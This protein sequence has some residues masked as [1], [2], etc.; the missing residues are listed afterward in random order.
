MRKKT[1]CQRFG[2]FCIASFLACMAF[3]CLAIVPYM[4]HAFRPFVAV[5]MAF[6]RMFAACLLWSFCGLFAVPGFLYSGRNF[7]ARYV[8]KIAVYGLLWPCTCIYTFIGVLHFLWLFCGRMACDRI[9]H[10]IGIWRGSPASRIAAGA[11]AGNN[12]ATRARKE[13]CK[14]TISNLHYVYLWFFWVIFRS[15]TWNFPKN[16]PGSVLD[17]AREMPPEEAGKGRLSESHIY[18]RVWK[19]F[20]QSDIAYNAYVISHRAD[21]SA[22]DPAAADRLFGEKISICAYDLCKFR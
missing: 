9:R 15:G 21:A 19:K 13:L 5:F 12:Y 11:V 14:P 3:L 6:C 20:F 18:A 17:P 7:R 1:S 22:P 4:R 2:A 8:V 16:F 10:A